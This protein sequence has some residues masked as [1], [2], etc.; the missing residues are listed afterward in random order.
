MVEW[1]GEC[2]VHRRHAADAAAPTSASCATCFS[3]PC[4]T[5][6]PA[7]ARNGAC[8]HGGELM[9]ERMAE[10]ALSRV[11]TCNTWQRICSGLLPRPK[12]PRANLFHG[13]VCRS[14]RARQCSGSARRSS[15]TFYRPSSLRTCRSLCLV[16][17]SASSSSLPRPMRPLPSPST[18]ALQGS[19]RGSLGQHA[20][21]PSVPRRCANIRLM[22]AP[23]KGDWTACDPAAWR[24]RTRQ[25]VALPN[26]KDC[27]IGKTGIDRGRHG[28]HRAIA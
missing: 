11:R 10:F 15:T 24:D 13:W 20:S 14:I 26:R 12:T 19:L 22:S 28:R 7:S 6:M 3:S 18:P 27:L 23:Y 17:L 25:R 21:C 5:P 8:C 4:A 2:V 1:S 9:P 16:L